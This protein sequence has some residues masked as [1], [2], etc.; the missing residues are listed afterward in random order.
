M[1]KFILNKKLSKILSLFIWKKGDTFSLFVSFECST[2]IWC[3]SVLIARAQFNKFGIGTD[4]DIAKRIDKNDYNE[5]YN[6]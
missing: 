4:S 3:V 5:Y 1:A 6:R 2:W